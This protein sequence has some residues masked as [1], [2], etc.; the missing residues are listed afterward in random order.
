MSG[1]ELGE[2]ILHQQNAG[3]AGCTYTLVKEGWLTLIYNGR[4]LTLEP[5]DLYIYSPGFQVTII[6]GSEDYHA[7][8]LM[9]DEGLTLQMPTIRDIIRTAY[10][11]IAE[12]GQPVVRVPEAYFDRLWHRMHEVIDYLQS[13]HRFRTEV[14]RTLYTLFLL[15]LTDI[16]E[17]VVT[18]HKYSERTAE[19]FI[20][21]MRLLPQH[22]VRHH[23]IAF[24]AS[25]L[26]ITTTHLSRVVRQIT[27]RTVVD[28]INQMLLM[29]ASFLLQTTDLPLADITER[30]H[31]A[32]PS[33][34]SK[35]FLRMKGVTPKRYRR[36]K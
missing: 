15:D 19:L 16:Q 34:F 24:Y 28:Y 22:F 33:S 35:F 32:D 3:F 11:P 21:F 2:H 23:D 26:C 36:E 20:A 30:L 14:L 6:S 10:L 27:G 1:N 7:V 17:R 4:Q 12:W 8:C 31:F 5:G 13:S 18:Q 25:E 9:A 29:E